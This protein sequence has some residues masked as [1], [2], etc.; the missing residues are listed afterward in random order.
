[1][2]IGLIL[3]SLLYYCSCIYILDIGLNR[4]C[5]CYENWRLMRQMANL[6]EYLKY[7]SANKFQHF[8]TGWTDHILLDLLLLRLALSSCQMEISISDK[9]H[10]LSDYSLISLPS[11]K[12]VLCSLMIISLQTSAK[13]RSDHLFHIY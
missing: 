1:M 7:F 4:I 8:A 10:L 11:L 6:V 2:N 3:A 5:F 12:Y 9:W 13:R